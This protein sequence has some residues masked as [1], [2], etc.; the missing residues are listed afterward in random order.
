MKKFIK[1]LTILSFFSAVVACNNQNTTTSS[2]LP[3][4]SSPVIENPTRIDIA[5]ASYVEVTKTIPLVADVVTSIYDDVTW[6]SENES[7]ASINENGIV[8]GISEGSATIRATSVKYPELT[9]THEVQVTVPK[10]TSISLFVE[11]N[12]NVT[13]D[14]QTNFY[15]VPLGQIFYVNYSCS[16]AHGRTPDSIS[17]EVLIDGNAAVD[18]NAY[19]LEIQE[20]NR[21][22]VVF[23]DILN[24]VEI[25]VSARYGDYFNAPT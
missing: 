18:T 4:T 2:T 10:I 23:Y 16:P 15:N 6:S 7:V 1:L 21:A 11:G 22:K 25:V 5:G 9:A 3:S 14:S 8:T 20:D 24:G 19:S 12:D 13:E 17:Y